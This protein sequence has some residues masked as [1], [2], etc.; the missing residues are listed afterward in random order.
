MGKVEKGFRFNRTDGRPIRRDET[1]ALRGGTCRNRSG[2]GIPGRFGTE[3]GSFREASAPARATA[4]APKRCARRR[5]RPD[6]PLAWDRA[7]R[8]ILPAS[9]ARQ[10]W[11]GQS[12]IGRTEELRASI[13]KG[14]ALNRFLTTRV[15]YFLCVLAAVMIPAGFVDA[16]GF[17]RRDM[18]FVSQGVKCAGWYYVPAA[19]KPGERRPAIVMAHGYSGV[20]EMFLDAVA[21]KFA[22]GGFV[23]L[24]FDYRH[25]GASEGEPRQQIFWYEQIKDYRNAITWLGLQPEVDASRIGVWG[26]SYSGGHVLQLAAF[27]K[28]VKAV[29]S[30]VPHASA[31]ILP[32][33]RLLALSA[34][35]A[36]ARALR[37]KTGQV[38]YVPVVAPAGQPSVLSQPEA[39]EPMLDAGRRAP[40]WENR[41]SVESLETTLE[42]D[43]SVFIHLIS[44]A[45]L[46]MVIASDDVIT[47]TAGQRKAFE[48]AGEPK[49]LVVVPG[50][51]FDAYEG[52][53]HVQFFT[54]QLEWFQLHLV[55]KR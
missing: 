52:P 4:D 54:P 41:V 17:E 33:D 23:V 6:R 44:P 14:G 21:S 49:S 11:A 25:L 13:T 9:E 27:D 39:Y 43:P 1:D 22:D 18:T 48:R 35:F 36:E 31:A 10:K 42:Y 53:K 34:G 7:L 20:K 37:L 47:P 28:R 50:R 30:Q 40:R 8:P 29:V 3:G 55:N 15:V 12:T 2:P 19:M 51:H 45:P 38:A 24:V 32:P 16:A 46:L 26:T 5:A